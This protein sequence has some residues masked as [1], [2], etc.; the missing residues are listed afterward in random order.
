[1]RATILLLL[2]ALAGCRAEPPREL[3]TADATHV[4]ASAAPAGDGCR[5]TSGQRP[6]TSI[7][8]LDTVAV[9]SWRRAFGRGGVEYTCEIHPTLALRFVPV[10]DPAGPSVDSVVVH[11]TG[12]SARA[13]QVLSRQPGEAESPMPY[14]TDIL[15]AIDLDADGWRDLLVGKFWGA[16]GNRGYDV[17]R[18]APSAH[19]FVA[20]T[21]LSQLCNP[22]P[23]PG[24]A[25][26][27]SHANSSARDDGTAVYC[28]HAGRWRLDSAV[29][30]HWNR[31]SSTVTRTTAARRGD[32]LVL[33]RR[34][35]RPDSI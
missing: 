10:V 9:D 8:L 16:T 20:D 13:L 26:I 28:L 24:R 3:R 31:D 19:R 35:T 5:Q 23:I 25:C 12:E 34:E 1:M 22:D 29:T 2:F 15:R 32:S 4:T 6:D 33:L 14:Y 17:W 27:A 7:R 18:Y 11:A 21:M 30:N